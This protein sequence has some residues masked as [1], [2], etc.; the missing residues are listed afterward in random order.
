[1]SMCICSECECLVDS[2]DDP[3]CFCEVDGEEDIVLCIHC[4]EDGNLF[5]MVEDDYPLKLIRLP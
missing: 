1:M 2:D 5:E 4:R 3:E